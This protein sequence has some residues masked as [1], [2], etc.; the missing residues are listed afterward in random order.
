ML[1][2]ISVFDTEAQSRVLTT[3][4]IEYGLYVVSMSILSSTHT[5]NS[6]RF[7]TVLYIFLKLVFL[8]STTEILEVSVTWFLFLKPRNL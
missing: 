5:T 2:I 3:A 7:L 1:T 6:V 8:S 4:T